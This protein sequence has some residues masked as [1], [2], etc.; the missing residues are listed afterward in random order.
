M[1]RQVP[2]QRETFPAI[3]AS[4]RP[5]VLGHVA[6]EVLV[7]EQSLSANAAPELVLVCVHDL[8]M[9][10]QR[11]NAVVKLAANFADVPRVFVDRR[12]GRQVPLEL[13]LLVTDRAR[14][15]VIVRVASNSVGSQVVLGFRAVSAV[16]A[17]EIRVLVDPMNESVYLQVALVLEAFAAVEEVAA[18]RSLA[19]VLSLNVPQKFATMVEA[20]FAEG[21]IEDLPLSPKTGKTDKVCGVVGG[22][23]KGTN[24]W[25][26]SA[27]TWENVE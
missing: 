8:A 26:H 9:L 24:S 7:G 5:V 25:T 27:V 19:T 15:F 4:V 14:E 21:A 20:F 1:R 18:K 17:W 11:V 13:E 16:L 12:V 23:K 22:K 3:V 10:V 2:L 6:L